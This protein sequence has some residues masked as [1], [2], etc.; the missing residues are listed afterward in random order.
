MLRERREQAAAAAEPFTPGELD[1]RRRAFKRLAADFPGAL[2]ELDASDALTLADKLSAVQ[3]EART[4]ADGGS[5]T[6]RW[7]LVVIDFHSILAGLLRLKLAVG[8]GD[9]VGPEADPVRRPAGG[10]LLPLVWAELEKRHGL[11][12]DE[13]IEMVFGRQT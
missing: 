3:A 7:V 8:R 6:R 13:L 5:V 1:E 2:R 12:R 4:V 11:R 10:R 9:P